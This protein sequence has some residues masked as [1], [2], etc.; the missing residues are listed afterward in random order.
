MAERKSA[1]R[2]ISAVTATQH[3]RLP[4]KAPEITATVDAADTADLPPPLE[5]ETLA[6]LRS[7]LGPILETA[8]SWDG[9]RTELA[10]HGYSIGFHTGRL[11]LVNEYGRAVCTGRCLGTPLSV[12]AAR[13]GRPHVRADRS[14]RHGWLH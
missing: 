7:F 5:S 1:E 14:G 9:L 13:L 3:D 8:H 4:T 2:R 11:V 6:L 12:L 10:A